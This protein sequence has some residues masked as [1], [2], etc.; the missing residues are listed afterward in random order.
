MQ[1]PHGG[2]R[3]E[4]DDALA[5]PRRIHRGAQPLLRVRLDVRDLGALY[6][7]GQG[8]LQLVGAGAVEVLDAA[9]VEPT[10]RALSWYAAATNGSSF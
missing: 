8:L 3:A 1:R 4:H 10:A 6:L 7:G 5:R 2:V 9:A